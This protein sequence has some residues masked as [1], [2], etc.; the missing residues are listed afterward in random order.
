VVVAATGRIGGDVDVATEKILLADTA[1][2][3]GGKWMG[4]QKRG[5]SK[6]LGRRAYD[7]FPAWQMWLWFN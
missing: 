3:Q 4:E 7:G 6:S 1:D 2:Q 5:Q